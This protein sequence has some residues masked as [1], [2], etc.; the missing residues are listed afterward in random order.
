[1][2]VLIF[3]DNPN[4][5]ETQL[6]RRELIDR[7]IETD[8]KAPWDISLPDYD[9]DYDL[10]YVPSN[11]LH[12]GTTFELLHR[13]LILRRLDENATVINPVESMLHYSKEHLS[14][15]LSRLGLPHPETMITENVEKAYGFAERLLEEGR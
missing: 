5:G 8:Y 4:T 6:V 1:M 14:L 15:Q 3:T 9:P 11:M 12:R 2:S 10:V 13:F 7:G